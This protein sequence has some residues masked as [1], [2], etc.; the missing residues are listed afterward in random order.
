MCWGKRAFQF[1]VFISMG[2]GALLGETLI[3]FTGEG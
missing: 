2:R 3:Y 1:L